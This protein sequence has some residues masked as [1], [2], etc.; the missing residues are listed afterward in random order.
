MEY[1]HDDKAGDRNGNAQA[2]G[3]EEKDGAII[4]D[5]CGVSNDEDG[6][7]DG[8]N[9][10]HSDRDGVHV[11]TSLKVF[12]DVSVGSCLLLRLI[13]LLGNDIITG[14][15][16]NTLFSATGAN[17]ALHEE[18]QSHEHR[19]GERQRENEVVLPFESVL[20]PVQQLHELKYM[21]L[22]EIE[23]IL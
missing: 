4:M 7:H 2:G 10:A 11:A 6:V 1:G 14:L 12:V 15:L 18:E 20:F 8:G 16:P 5:L 3:I 9:D 23:R 22:I 13:I 19:D 17:L 21:F